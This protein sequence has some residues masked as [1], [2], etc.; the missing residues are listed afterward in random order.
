G[1]ARVVRHGAAPVPGGCGR[2]GRG[3]TRADGGAGRAFEGWASRLA[4]RDLGGV[5]RRVDAERGG[6]PRGPAQARCPPDARGARAP[7]RPAP[8]TPWA[9]D[10]RSATEPPTRPRPG[11]STTPRACG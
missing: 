8:S 11:P 1:A 2:A 5:A 7:R 9:T 6:D 4:Q 3:P 10:T